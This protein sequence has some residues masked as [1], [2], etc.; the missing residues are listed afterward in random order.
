MI[1]NDEQTLNA[2]VL[3]VT[4]NHAIA[5]MALGFGRL[6]AHQVTHTSA[7]ALYFSRSS[8]LETLLRAG[9]GLH[10]RHN[11]NVSIE[12]WSAKVKLPAKAQKESSKIV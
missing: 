9:V 4:D 12:K 3:C 6:F 8:H 2:S 11:K 1:S 5:Q 10:F 7:V